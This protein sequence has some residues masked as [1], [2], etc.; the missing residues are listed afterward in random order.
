MKSISQLIS[1]EI[2][3]FHIRNKNHKEKQKHAYHLQPRKDIFFIGSCHF[4]NNVLFYCKVT[5]IK[6]KTKINSIDFA[7][8]RAKPNQR[9]DST[10]SFVNYF[11]QKRIF[12]NDCKL[13]ADVVNENISNVDIEIIND[14]YKQSERNQNNDDPHTK[15]IFLFMFYGKPGKP[16]HCLADGSKP[17]AR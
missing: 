8:F 14:I 1:S 7:A 12:L 3:D 17:V 13:V 16:K 9:N 4:Y 6:F 11:R 2:P 5:E 15:T 10:L